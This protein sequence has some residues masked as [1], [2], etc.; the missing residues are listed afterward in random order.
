MSEFA[1][2]KYS[3]HLSRLTE[4]LAMVMKKRFNSIHKAFDW[5]QILISAQINK[6]VVDDTPQ[7]KSLGKSLKS[8]WKKLG[9]FI[10]YQFQT[11][12]FFNGLIE[13]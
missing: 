1:L 9:F 11:Q 10:L 7:I 4:V 2:R 8:Y 6:S 12:F 5:I 3:L 13:K